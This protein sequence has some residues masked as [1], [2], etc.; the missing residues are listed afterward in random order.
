VVRVLAKEKL[1]KGKTVGVDA[2]TLEANAAM[3]SIVRRD[4]GETYR[5]YVTCLAKASGIETPTDEEVRKFDKKRKKK[6]SNEDWHNPHDPD[7]RVT[8]MKD[9]RTHLAHK[10]E[11]VTDLATNAI[12]GLTL[13]PGDAG[14]SQS[15]AGSLAQAAQTL[16]AVAADPEACKHI[17]D[18]P[19]TEVVTDKGYHSNDTLLHLKGHNIR[20]YIAEPD[21]GRRKWD[22]KHDARDAVYANRRRIKGNRAA[23][24]RCQR[25]ERVERGFAH[26]YDTGGMGRIHLRGHENIFKRLLVHVSG[27]NLGLLMRKICGAGT[28]RGLKDL[29]AMF[30][31]T[32][33]RVKC[34]W[35]VSGPFQT[36]L[37]PLTIGEMQLKTT[38]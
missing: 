7:A 34:S 1:V 37:R 32:A 27:H 5:A 26:N 24:L 36:G 30:W 38:S 29:I 15:L 4:T 18:K 25:A 10:A 3:R 19:L 35:I 11:H 14:D 6:T 33:G 23:G 13:C 17:H 31:A 21:R 16:E 9:G 28:S 12:V 22:G 8:K 2:T 20:S